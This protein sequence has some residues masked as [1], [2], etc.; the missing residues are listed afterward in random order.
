MNEMRIIRRCPGCGVSL[1]TIDQQ[2]PGNVPVKH[3]DRH[4]VVL[5]QRCVKLQH[6]GED[7]APLS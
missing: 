4:E 5:C 6:Y 7:V 2:L 3:V 1:Q